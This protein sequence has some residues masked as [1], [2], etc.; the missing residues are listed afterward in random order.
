MTG[1]QFFHGV[2]R[3]QPGA[4]V[5][6]LRLLKN[7][8]AAD[9]I[10]QSPPVEHSADQGFQLQPFAAVRVFPGHEA[11][12]VSGQ[13]TGFRFQTVSNGLNF[14]VGEQGGRLP[15]DRSAIGRKRPLRSFFRWLGSSAR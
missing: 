8:E 4:P 14:V 13:R 12:E 3:H 6:A 1:C 2:E 5:F 9:K 7:D 15:A 10:K 11:A